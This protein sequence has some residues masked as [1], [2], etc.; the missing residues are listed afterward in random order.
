MSGG[1]KIIKQSKGPVTLRGQFIRAARPDMPTV[2]AFPDLCEKPEVLRPLFN[3]KFHEYRNLWLLSYRNSWMS[4]R[5][6]SMEAEEIAE[7]VTNFMNQHNITTA[8]LLGHGFGARIATITGILK[9]HRITS[10]VGLDYSPMDYT[11]HECWKELKAAVELASSIELQS[12]TRNEVVALLRNNIHNSRLRQVFTSNLAEAEN[13]QLFWRSGMKEL[14]ASMNLKDFRAN[15]GRF[16]LIGLFPGRAMF[17]YAERGNWVH[18]SSNTIPIYNLFPKL[19]GEYGYFIDHV[20]TDNHWLF[21]TD[22]VTSMSRRIADFYRWYDG[23]HHL[24]KDR[25][26]I[27]KI[28]VPVRARSDLT[29]EEQQHLIEEGNP[30]VP[31]MVPPHYHHNYAFNSEASKVKFP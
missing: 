7:D 18:Q 3:K 9:Y 30:T 10:V 6:D 29:A 23:V 28:A 1:V 2:I 4:N 11:E 25:S 16:P 26:E 20:N 31:K 15:I 21:E 19:K 22:H 17:F 12:K 5:A 24:L 13:G 14:A 27:G 8:S